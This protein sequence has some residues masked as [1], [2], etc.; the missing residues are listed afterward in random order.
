MASRFNLPHIDITAR[1]TA[2][3]YVGEGAF[4]T[5]AVRIRAEHG[6]RIQNELRVALA[7]ADQKRPTD[8]RLEPSNTSV[9]EV[10]LRRGTLP[11]VLDMKREGIRTGAAKADDANVRT[12]ALHVP[13]HARP[14]L[15][16]ILDE[17]LHGEL[18]SVGQNPPNRTK[19]ESIEA[20]REA[21]LATLW[22][23]QKSYPWG[24]PS[25][26]LVGALVF[27]GP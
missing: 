7:A 6:A 26:H 19:V 21:R 8:D 3:D 4:G 27:Q 10:E 22:T 18:T 25:V 9:I 1:A 5:P 16:Q 15:D 14:I 2:Q 12:I 11:D 23:D 17:Y 24:K 13:D 20:I